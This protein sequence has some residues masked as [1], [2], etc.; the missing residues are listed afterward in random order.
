MCG[1]GEVGVMEGSCMTGTGRDGVGVEMVVGGVVG[2][3]VG[4]G[5]L[6]TDISA[7]RATSCVTTRVATTAWMAGVGAAVLDTGKQETPLKRSINTN[8][9]P[10]K[11]FVV[12][13]C[14]F[15]QYISARPIVALVYG[16]DGG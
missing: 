4:S 15:I 11:Y 2:V 7:T 9:K 5:V 13:G 10:L 6:V 3:G 14:L 16:G 8:I 1:G 12:T